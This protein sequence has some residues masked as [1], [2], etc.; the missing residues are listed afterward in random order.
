MYTSIHLLK[1]VRL[2]FLFLGEDIKFHKNSAL[3]RLSKCQWL[4]T[5]FVLTFNIIHNCLEGQKYRQC[6]KS[7]FVKVWRGMSDMSLLWKSWTQKIQ[8]WD[9]SLFSQRSSICLKNLVKYLALLVHMRGMPL[10][11][12]YNVND[13]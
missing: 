4:Y 11:S 5:T 1:P 13:F 9:L 6:F 7:G 12:S 10:L 3:P 8:D 2:F